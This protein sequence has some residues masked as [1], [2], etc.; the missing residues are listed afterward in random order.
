MSNPSPPPSPFP[1]DGAESQEVRPQAAP[2]GVPGAADAG[3]ATPAA[4]GTGGTGGSAGSTGT[5]GGP[6]VEVV[7]E[8]PAPGSDLVLCAVDGSEGSLWA[9]DRAFAEAAAYR[10]TLAV[11]AVVNPAPDGFV[12]GMAEIV[13]DSVMRLIESMRD[14]AERAIA[15]VRANR[16]ELQPPRIVLHVLQGNAIALLLICSRGQHTLVVGS[17]GNGGFKRLLLGSV[18]TAMVH[19][20]E[21]PVL[22]VPA[23]KSD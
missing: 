11:L 16:P 18:S 1:S 9:L 2:S 19:H 21:C 10:K 4:A 8:L 7:D 6:E 13:Q 5:A 12:A 15:Q 14:V 20:A 17:R 22:V 23:P 3:P